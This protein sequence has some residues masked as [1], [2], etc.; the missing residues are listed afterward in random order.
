MKFDSRSADAFGQVDIV[1]NNA[2]IPN[3]APL[4]AWHKDRP[5]AGRAAAMRAF[6]AGLLVA[7][8]GA[9]AADEPARPQPTAERA[10]ADSVRVQPT[11][12][13]FAPPNQPDVSAS[14]ASAI[15][16]LYR[17]LIGPPP[18][19]SSGSRSSTPPSGSAKR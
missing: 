2:G 9:R 16:K 12:K 1:V 8:L 18:P 5:A 13:Q 17:Q 3:V 7:A 11:A 15:D 6:A 10:V 19:T 14:D 4:T